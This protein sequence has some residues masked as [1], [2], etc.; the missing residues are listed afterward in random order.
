MPR[1]YIRIVLF[2][3]SYAPLLALFGVRRR[4]CLPQLIALEVVAVL[5][6]LVLWAFVRVQRGYADASIKIEG[7]DTKDAETLGYIATYLVPL[8]S[9][10]LGNFDDVLAL[11][12]FA[13]VLGVVYCNSSLMYTNPMLNLMGYHLFEVKESGGPTWTL[14]SK[15]KHLNINQVTTSRVGDTMIRVEE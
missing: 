3:S 1:L 6:V 15:R 9:L 4:H 13:F 8:L 5:S 12:V 14:L 11:G 10:N 2:L 7:W